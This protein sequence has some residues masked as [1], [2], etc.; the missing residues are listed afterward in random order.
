MLRELR[1]LAKETAIYGLST[2]L[3]RMLG[4]LL[5]P[6]F[7]HLLLPSESGVVQTVYSCIGF[8]AVVY[9]MGLDVAYLRLGRPDRKPDD[10][11]FTGALCA[12]LALALTVSGLLHLFSGTVAAAL[13][14]PASLSVVVRYAAWILAIDAATLI[15]YT[16]LRG[17][18]Y[19]GTFAGIKIVNISMT[20][21]LSWFF[22][23][24]L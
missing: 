6:L 18:H 22:V 17:A 20:L 9:G 12:V 13:G 2:V 7:T 4:F 16:E 23:G 1:G 8:L 15:P 11:A 10:G 21:I 5:T 24:R 3:G 19:A 14:I